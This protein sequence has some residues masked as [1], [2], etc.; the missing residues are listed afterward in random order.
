MR[1]GHLMDKAH[2]FFFAEGAQR[3]SSGHARD[4]Q[5]AARRNLRVGE[6]KCF[7]L[8][9]YAPV[10]LFNRGDLAYLNTSAR[11]LIRIPIRHR[12]WPHNITALVSEARGLHLIHTLL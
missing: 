7:A 5:M 6:P 11:L 9:S 8:Q 3:P 2:K 10:I 4:D 1:C 12:G